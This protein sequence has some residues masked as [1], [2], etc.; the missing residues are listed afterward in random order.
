M[1]TR[2]FWVKAPGQGVL[3][4]ETLPPLAPDQVRVR[5]LFSGISRGTE[6]L[7]F[8]G[9]VPESLWATMRCPHQ[10]GEFSLP[11][12]YGYITV[13]EIEAGAGPVG[14]KIFCLHP[15]QERFN[16]AAEAVQPLPD[17]LPPG[18]A[19]LAA[20]LETAI[21]GVW[22]GQPGP[23]DRVTVIGAGVVGALVAW[24]VGRIP[25]TRVQLV[26][27]AAQRAAVAA[28]LGVNFSLPADAE[29]NQDRVFHCSGSAAGLQQALE[30]TGVEGMVVELSWFG[31]QAVSLPLGGAFHPNRITIRSSQVGRIPPDRL[32]RWDYARR[33]G[34]ALDL[35][36]RHP[37]LDSLISG[38][39][40]FEDLPDTMVRLAKGAGEV[41]CHRVRY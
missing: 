19:V 37:E 13:G 30:L 41:L 5:T 8:R 3:L 21:N 38:E 11:I 12:K 32:P 15:H 33:M 18:R 14:Q 2:A 27:T 7:V 10:E 6:S 36:A 9:G 22:D 1:N 26:D 23:G 40:A 17:E 28:G 34:V 39:S 16:I 4:D 25:G 35:L 29:G 31:D 20:N 24:L